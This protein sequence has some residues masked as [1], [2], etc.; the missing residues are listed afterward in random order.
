MDRASER[1]KWVRGGGAEAPC[2]GAPSPHS[3]PAPTP[4]TL[5]FVIA[6]APGESEARCKHRSGSKGSEAV[7][8]VG[9]SHRGLLSRS[10]PGLPPKA[11]SE[12][13]AEAGISRP[14]PLGGASAW[15]RQPLLCQG[16]FL[17]G[18][19]AA[20]A[21][22]G[23]L[24][25]FEE[26]GSGGAGPQGSEHSSYPPPW[27][28]KGP[29]VSGSQAGP[30]SAEPHQPALDQRFLAEHETRTK[31]HGFRPGRFL[32]PQCSWGLLGEQKARGK[33]HL[34]LFF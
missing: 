18:D 17:G 10:L 32:R 31:G 34:I 20:A 5:H 19:T 30:Q 15:T 23:S 13:G 12:K 7:R 4:R 9:S 33:Q 3:S 26:G 14:L 11:T 16:Q 22:L 24:R 21:A 1:L 28:P 29:E 2:S 27:N 6:E 8:W 25:H